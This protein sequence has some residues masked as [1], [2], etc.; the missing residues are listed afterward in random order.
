MRMGERSVGRRRR[1]GGSLFVCDEDW[2]FAGG[3]K[4]GEEGGEK[5]LSH[6]IFIFFHAPT[7]DLPLSFRWK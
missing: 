7:F 2:Q 4:R 3:E 5:E 6:P 1:K